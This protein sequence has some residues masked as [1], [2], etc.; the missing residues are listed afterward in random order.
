MSMS[1]NR[2]GNNSWAQKGLVEPLNAVQPS[3]KS[4]GRMASLSVDAGNRKPGQRIQA[5]PPFSNSRKSMPK[6]LSRPCFSVFALILGLAFAVDSAIAAIPFMGAK[7]AAD[8]KSEPRLD[9]KATCKTGNNTYKILDEM[10]TSR[11]ELVAVFEMLNYGRT[12]R[13][14]G[15]LDESIKCYAIAAAAIHNLD[16][17]TALKDWLESLADVGLYNTLILLGRDKQARSIIR[18]AVRLI[19]RFSQARKSSTSPQN[20]PSEQKNSD[21]SIDKEIQNFIATTYLKAAGSVMSVSQREA[22]EYL[23]KGW[24]IIKENDDSTRSQYDDIMLS[25][26]QLYAIMGSNKQVID[27]LTRLSED[28]EKDK[29]IEAGVKLANVYS[30]LADAYLVGSNFGRSEFYFRIANS[31]YKQNLPQEEYHY[32]M[33]NTMIYRFENDLNKAFESALKAEISAKNSNNSSH[34]ITAVAARCAL[35]DQAKSITVLNSL[36]SKELAFVSQNMKGFETVNPTSLVQ[37][38]S[39]AGNVLAKGNKPSA[40]PILNYSF[41]TAL[42]NLG[43]NNILTINASI[44]LAKLQERT[45]MK[46]AIDLYHE[47]NRLAVENYLTIQSLDTLQRASTLELRS[48]D[49]LSASKTANRYAQEALYL[50]TQAVPELPESDKVSFFERLH[51]NLLHYLAGLHPS[52]A[53]QGFRYSI[54][55]RG[56]LQSLILAVKTSN[57][58]KDA[59]NLLSGLN[60]RFKELALGQQAIRISYR[61]IEPGE[62]ARALPANSVY[63]HFQR[64]SNEALSDERDPDEFYGAYILDHK[65]VIKFAKLGNAQIIDKQI[66][67]THASLAQDLTNYK[68]ETQVLYRLIIKPLSSLIGPRANI[69]M[70]LDSELNRVPIAPLFYYWQEAAMTGGDRRIRI[71]S[72]PRDLVL[73]QKDDPTKSD[74]GQSIVIADPLYE[75]SDNAEAI[76]QPQ[77]NSRGGP[78]GAKKTW[79]QLRFARAEGE[80]VSSVLDGKLVLGKEATKVNMQSVAS[81]LVLHVAA[82]AFFDSLGKGGAGG[83]VSQYNIYNHYSTHSGIALAGQAGD[84]G[85]LTAAEASELNLRNTQLVVLSGCSTGEGIAT[86]GQGV[87]GLYRAFMEAGAK[88]LLM[89]LWEVDDQAT[90]EFM[91]RFYSKLKEGRSRVDALASTQQEFRNGITGHKDWER[92]YY[93]AA[94]QLV[95]DWRPINGL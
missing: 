55:E 57:K 47:I 12:L 72:I 65:G 23:D 46:K 32:E 7:G 29:R 2:N 71:V 81:P 84:D 95:G 8:G 56:L 63:I 62:L 92:P 80:A 70:S 75:A 64:Y 27:I 52:A 34:W 77:D 49:L 13:E 88:S 16:S 3:N 89:S 78:N 44:G 14:S 69:Y 5:L 25:Y 19:E 83:G 35:A 45:N 11:K 6:A 42:K 24:N 74:V 66:Q 82:H 28:Y 61:I 31:V 18:N 15:N 85:I 76:S 59:S 39:C 60:G 53:Y 17:K 54:N 4:L 41:N 67:A 38:L 90:M 10:N 40:A 91:K 79:K 50:L 26:K 94:W 30:D 1:M 33:S 37:F 73:A 86:N 21:S 9:T 43:A 22:I 51:D 58:G 68:N 48:N 87:F 20:T 36:L 93:W